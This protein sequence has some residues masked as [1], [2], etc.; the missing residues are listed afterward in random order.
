MHCR[1][2]GTETKRCA[3][4]QSLTMRCR[5]APSAMAAPARAGGRCGSLRRSPMKCGRSSATGYAAACRHPS[6]SAVP[7]AWPPSA[8]HRVLTPIPFNMGNRQKHGLYEKNRGRE[9]RKTEPDCKKPRKIGHSCM[10]RG[11][12]LTPKPGCPATS[13]PGSFRR[14]DAARVQN[15]SEDFVQPID[16][17][18][19]T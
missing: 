6:G 14:H 11:L 3:V 1:P 17:N 15:I 10:L 7:T 18:Y 16:E 12:V 2:E 5:F 19:T 9:L 4:G 13:W 8:Q